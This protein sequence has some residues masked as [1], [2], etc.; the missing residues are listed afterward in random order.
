MRLTA[1]E[2]LALGVGALLLSFGAAVR[3]LDRQ[4][5]IE[6]PAASEAASSD[7]EL[8]ELEGEVE[9]EVVEEQRRDLPLAA[10]E[11][12]DPNLA[13]EIELDRLPRVGPALAG[14]I[15][16]YREA[17]GPFRTLAD[18]DAV[19]GIGPV[20]LATITPLIDLPAAPP[21]APMPETVRRSP[22]GR[23]GS[24]STGTLDLNRASA[25][26]LERLPGI[27]PALA[28]RIV[29]WREEHGLFRTVAELERVPGIGPRTVERL[30]P[31]ARVS[32]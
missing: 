11:R 16:A 17:N 24:S 29:Q 22:A 15:V 20:L 26:E 25:A 5:P 27:G 28:E 10:G 2:R 3:T 6:W 19:P 23:A 13:S 7:S 1:Q 32:R 4:P 8:A 21:P 31:L 12:L 9:A 30:A 14:R 18:L